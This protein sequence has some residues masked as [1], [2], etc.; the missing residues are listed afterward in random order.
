MGWA[1]CLSRIGT[2]LRTPP[3]TGHS[4]G[5]HASNAVAANLPSL[6]SAVCLPSL[7]LV[8]SQIIGKKE[9][10]AQSLGLGVIACIGELLEERESGHTFDVV[11][12]QLAAIAGEASRAALRYSLF[13][14]LPPKVVQAAPT[15]R[16]FVLACHR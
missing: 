11:F 15:R 16:C 14:T 4:S 13:G 5:S 7:L 1:P 3:C 9:A 6:F 10:Y 8:S 12:A 2:Q